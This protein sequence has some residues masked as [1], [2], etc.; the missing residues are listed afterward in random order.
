[1]LDM[2][3]C[4]SGSAIIGA[5]GGPNNTG[6]RL[7]FSPIDAGDRPPPPLGALAAFY[8]GAAQYV[9]A[10]T[11]YRRAL[12]VREASLGPD[13]ADVAVILEGLAETLQAMQRS[14]EATLIAGRTEGIRA[15]DSAP[16]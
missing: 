8:A 1:M 2:A 15:R 11:L 10:E 5:V 12:A 6:V 7:G 9:E 4:P 13:H 16:E 14:A 3:I